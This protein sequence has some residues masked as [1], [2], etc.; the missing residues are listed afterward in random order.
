MHIPFADTLS[1]RGRDF[2]LIDSPLEAYFD[3]IA[4]RPQFLTSSQSLR[5]YTAQWTIEDGWLYLTGITACWPDATPVLIEHLFP[6]GG[7]RV[8]AAWYSGRLRG[9]RVA[10]SPVAL[11]AFERSPDIVI[12]TH[13]GRLQTSSIV[14]RS[15][16]RET[17]PACPMTAAANDARVMDLRTGVELAS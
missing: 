16:G 8:F 7:G 2:D 14:H 13:C 15:R 1:Y 4:A 9:F 3:L 6:Y 5:G 11:S 10:A 12:S 17:R